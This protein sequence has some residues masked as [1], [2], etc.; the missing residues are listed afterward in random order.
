MSSSGAGSR[1]P[2]PQPARV[3][4]K[5]EGLERLVYPRTGPVPEV[6]QWANLG[7]EGQAF[8][9]W[10]WEQP[11]A[12]LWIESDFASVVRRAQIVDSLGA[13]ESTG[14]LHGQATALDKALGLSPEARMRMRVRFADEPARGNDGEKA[15]PANVLKLA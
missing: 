2:L 10:A 14:S 8:W 1:G 6:P 5:H 9:E 13:G 7:P 11:I 15:K 12:G 3:N 4:G